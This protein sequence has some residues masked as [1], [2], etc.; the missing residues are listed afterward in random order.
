MTL[1][2]KPTEPRYEAPPPAAPIRAAAQVAS[3]PWLLGQNGARYVY[4]QAIQLDAMAEKLRYG[5]LQRFPQYCQPE[6]LNPLGQDKRIFRGLSESDESYASRLQQFKPTWRLAGNAPTLLRQLWSLLSPDATRIRYVVNGYTGTPA[7]S[8]NQFADWWTIDDTGLAYER[9][10]PSNWNWDGLSIGFG[11]QIRFWLIVYRP[12]LSVPVWGEP[13][14][15]T[16]GESGYYWGLGNSPSNWIADFRNVVSTFRAAGSA[17]GPWQGY[18]GG[19]IVANPNETG[20]PWGAGGPFDPALPPGYP[21]PDG[22]FNDPTNRPT[23]GAVYLS[24][25]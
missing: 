23:V 12:D 10:S 21:M 5:E 7:S 4:S 1:Y 11:M 6:A 19:L 24:G 15:S 8:L 2:P 18:G 14:P 16:W 3:P 22:D 9:V 20:S 25:M 13:P 17:L